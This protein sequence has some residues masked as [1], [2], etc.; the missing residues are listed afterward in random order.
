M[1]ERVHAP[2]IDIPHYQHLAR[3]PDE[4]VAKE[5]GCSIRTYK[6]KISGFYDFSASELRVLSEMFNIC[7]DKLLAVA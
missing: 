1:R 6:E 2:Y 7:I 5:L 4:K 3:V